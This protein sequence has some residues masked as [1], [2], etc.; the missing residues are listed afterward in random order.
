MMYAKLANIRHE[1][2]HTDT[3]RDKLEVVILIN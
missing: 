3:S 1:W 2:S